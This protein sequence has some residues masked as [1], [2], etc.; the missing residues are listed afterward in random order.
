MRKCWYIQRTFFFPQILTTKVTVPH[1]DAAVTQIHHQIII[2][3]G[4]LCP[5]LVQCGPHPDCSVIS[6]LGVKLFSAMQSH[7]WYL[8][9][10]GSLQLAVIVT[11]PCWFHSWG[12]CSVVGGDVSVFF[13][14]LPTSLFHFCWI[15]WVFVS[16][17]MISNSFAKG[18]MRVRSSL[19]RHVLCQA[20][21]L[22]ICC[23][24]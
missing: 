6:V 10:T 16:V 11:E 23:F 5:S 4:L 12:V 3:S 20:V 24:P 21:S 22:L 13:P 15:V 17:A 8:T 18:S 7:L 14:L 19:T 2:S 1:S 9:Q